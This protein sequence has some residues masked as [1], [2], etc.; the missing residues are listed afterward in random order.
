MR[1]VESVSL[2]DIELP[3]DGSNLRTPTRT[4]W[5]E[6]AAD[7]AASIATTAATLPRHENVLMDIWASPFP[8]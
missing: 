1:F 3:M 4:S 5:P 6:A 7:V 8:S 2:D